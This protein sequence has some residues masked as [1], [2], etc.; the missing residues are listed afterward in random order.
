MDAKYVTIMLLSGMN[1]H[2]ADCA[3]EP[4]LVR[5]AGRVRRY[6]ETLVLAVAAPLCLYQ[7]SRIVTSPKLEP[8]AILPSFSS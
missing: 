8:S 6:P 7:S 2:A 1:T 3:A 5:Q 4:G